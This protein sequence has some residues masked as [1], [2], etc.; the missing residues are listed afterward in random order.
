M[1]IRVLVVGAG[2]GGVSAA[3]QLHR[4]GAHVH[5]WDR[6]GTIGGLII[7]AHCIEN[8]PG[9]PPKTSGRECCRILQ[10][11]ARQFGLVPQPRE[12]EHFFEDANCVV[13]TDTAGHCE[14]F[15]ALILA[16]GTTPIPWEHAHVSARVVYEYSHLPTDAHRILIVGGGE[17]G[18]DG[19]LQG[20][21]NGQDVVLVVRSQ[22]LK[23]RGLL[24]QRVL[25]DPRIC[26]RFLTQVQHLQ[27]Q[28]K[29][30]ICRFST[31]PDTIEIFDAVLFCGGR[32]S[33]LPL[34]FLQ[35][36]N[37]RFSPRIW[38]IGDVRRGSLGQGVI[39]AGDGVAAATEIMVT[40]V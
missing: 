13:V 3:V 15:D 6:L 17:A 37:M 9:M 16:I 33:V 38:V 18:C 11:H 19:A 8:W 21:E 4:L 26:V 23:A 10:A 40:L 25:T 14:T 36:Q 1:S 27:E 31:S 30:L 29:T 34:Q 24:A 2:P 7:N 5:W 20:V 35:S 39:A 32:T 22:Q 12:M 28:D